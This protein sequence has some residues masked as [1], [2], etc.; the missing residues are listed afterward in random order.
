MPN[1]FA[2]KRIKENSQSDVQIM[3][4][5]AHLSRADHRPRGGILQ[6]GNPDYRSRRVPV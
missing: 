5:A 1:D 2:R 4:P 6:Y 3:K